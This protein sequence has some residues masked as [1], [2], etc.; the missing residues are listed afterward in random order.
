MLGGCDGPIAIGDWAKAKAEW[1]KR[2]LAL[3]GGIPSHKIGRLLVAL[4]PAKFQS[5]FG[6]WITAI[7]ETKETAVGEHAEDLTVAS[8]RHIAID[9]KSLRRSHDRRKGLGPL[10]L[11]SA[12]A[13]N[14]RDL[15]RAVGHRKK[16]SN[17]ITAIPQLLE[18]IELKGSIVTIDA[19]TKRRSRRRS[20]LARV[21]TA[22]PSRGTRGISSRRHPTGWKPK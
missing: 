17:E 7:M 8:P 6:N 9:G 2:H 1:L 10:H 3:P 14:L 18:Q 13:V 11:V 21:T 22:W 19:V 15:A 16:K 12:W 20:L 5:C 4:K